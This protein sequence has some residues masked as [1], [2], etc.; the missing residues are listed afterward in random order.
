MTLP[1]KPFHHRVVQLA[2]IALSFV[3]WL[4]EQRPDA[5]VNCVSNRK[6]DDFAS[7]LDQPSATALLDG[8]DVVLLRQRHRNELVLPH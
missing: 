5:A 6:R 8:F 7:L 1:P 3:A 4:H 2:T